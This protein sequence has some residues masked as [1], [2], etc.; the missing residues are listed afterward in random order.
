MAAR[1]FTPEEAN[2]LLASI[3]P[4]AERMVEHR[5]KLARLLA[6]RT[7]VNTMIAGNGGGLGP[8]R[9]A[10]IEADLKAS[11]DGVHRCVEA[12]EELG[13]IVK[14]LDRGL[15]DFPTRRGDEEVLLCWQLGEEEIRFWHGLEEGFAG[16]RELD[17]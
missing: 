10:R 5:R 11:A 9:V 13:G 17:G 1:F 4:L 15:V 3:R 16:R 14:D 8:Q 7:K 12:I 2:A 6:Q